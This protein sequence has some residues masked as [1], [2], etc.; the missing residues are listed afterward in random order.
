MAKFHPAGFR[1]FASALAEA[2]IR[3]VLAHIQ[4]PTLLIYGD[5]D[6]RAPLK[7]AQDLHRKIP[8]SRLVVI[9]GVGHMSS[10]EAPE[11][12]NAEV[13]GFLRSLQS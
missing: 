3:D 5:K 11:R 2:D 1:A 13:R 9:P 10:V 4:V 8:G 6:V 12:F 7:V